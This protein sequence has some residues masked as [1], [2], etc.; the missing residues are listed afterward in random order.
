MFQGFLDIR[1]PE[2]G[3]EYRTLLQELEWRT[4]TEQIMVP[5]GFRTDYA[6]V[7]RAL[8]SLIPPTG[9]YTKAAVLHDWLYYVGWRTRAECDAMFLRAMQVLGVNPMLARLMYLGVRC[10][11][12]VGWNAYRLH[13]IHFDRD[14]K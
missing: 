2:D 10:G 6:S 7:P 11:G 14:V 8:W 9:Q 12:W 5:R 4:E 13:D 1:M 3:S